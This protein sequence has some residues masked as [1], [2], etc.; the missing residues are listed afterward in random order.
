MK[1]YLLPRVNNTSEGVGGRMMITTS[2][3][4]MT[5]VFFAVLFAVVFCFFNCISNPWVDFCSSE[6][7][8]SELDVVFNTAQ[9]PENF[10]DSSYHLKSEFFTE[11]NTLKKSVF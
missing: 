6:S 2:T 1:P 7:Q 10:A 9:L 11:K 8:I 4:S 5:R 3:M